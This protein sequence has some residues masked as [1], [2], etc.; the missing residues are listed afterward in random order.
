MLYDGSKV[1]SMKLINAQAKTPSIQYKADEIEAIEPRL[2]WQ[3]LFP[4]FLQ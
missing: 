4:S 1:G 2:I 3:L